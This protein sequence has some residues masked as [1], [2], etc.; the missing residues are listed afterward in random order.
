[1]N[2][3]LLWYSSV[4]CMIFSRKMLKSVGD[5]RHPFRNSTD[6]LKNVLVLLLTKTALFVFYKDF[7]L[8]Q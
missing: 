2:M 1:M 4:P 8:L 6:V 7:R 5:K 3:V